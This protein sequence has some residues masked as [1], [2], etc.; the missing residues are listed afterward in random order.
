MSS[1]LYMSAIVCTS[2]NFERKKVWLNF[3][4]GLTTTEALF[5]VYLSQ[6]LMKI[7]LQLSVLTN[8][9]S[10]AVKISPWTKESVRLVWKW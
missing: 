4:R 10:N 6:N 8:S 5:E 2:D 1:T 9:Q 7:Q 3:G